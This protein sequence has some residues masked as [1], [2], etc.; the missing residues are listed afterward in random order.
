MSNQDLRRKERVLSAA[1]LIANSTT[2]ATQ[3]IQF[4]AVAAWR[5]SGVV[6]RSSMTST[7]MTK[8]AKIP[9]GHSSVRTT[10]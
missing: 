6:A 8:S 1:H 10:F 9:I 5:N 4:R 3:M 7:G 2:K